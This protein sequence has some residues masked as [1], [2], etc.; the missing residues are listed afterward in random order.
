ME[1]H[2]RRPPQPHGPVSEGR[3]LDQGAPERYSMAA[4]IAG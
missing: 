3:V 1:T 2:P 4:S